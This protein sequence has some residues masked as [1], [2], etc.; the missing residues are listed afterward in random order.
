MVENVFAV[1]PEIRP[2]DVIATIANWLKPAMALR[3]ASS[4][5]GNSS[6][7]SLAIKPTKIFV[8]QPV[9]SGHRFGSLCNHLFEVVS[10]FFLVQ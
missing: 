10:P 9:C 4:R 3:L 5:V 2:D 6:P 8:Y 1:F 7:F